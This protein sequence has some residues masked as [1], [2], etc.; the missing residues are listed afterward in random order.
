MC[1]SGSAEGHNSKDNT[2]HSAD[3][4]TQ[5][6]SRENTADSDLESASGDCLTC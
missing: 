1:A 6:K 3:E 5:Y 2:D 4:S